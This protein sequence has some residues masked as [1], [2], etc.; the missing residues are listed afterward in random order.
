MEIG[1][2]QLFWRRGRWWCHLV[3]D[4]F[5]PSG[6]ARLHDWAARLGAPACAFHDPQG[7]LKPHYD[8]TPEL[9]ERAL[10]QGAHPLTRREVA[11]WLQRGRLRRDTTR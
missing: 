3:C 10:A 1:V 6:L 8:L 4:D 11:Q 7:K 2:D 9:R 5:S